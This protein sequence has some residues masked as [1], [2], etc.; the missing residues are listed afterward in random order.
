MSQIV[1]QGAA[2]RL[3]GQR[4][5][6]VGEEAVDGRAG[7]GHVGAERAERAQLVGERRRGE[8]VRR[9]RGEVAGRRERALGAG[10]APA[11]VEARRAVALVEAA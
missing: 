1:A 7:A 9:E 3:G 4:P 2:M 6:R 8:I 11:L 5:R 10:R